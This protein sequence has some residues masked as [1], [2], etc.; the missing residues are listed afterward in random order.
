MYIK[1][2]R[3]SRIHLLLHLHAFDTFL[4]GC[5][6]KFT[7]FHIKLSLHALMCISCTCA[8]VYVYND[9]AILIV[10]SGLLLIIMMFRI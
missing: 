6:R 3:E 1:C 8:R 5:C 4:I 10:I 2:T 9:I 7:Q